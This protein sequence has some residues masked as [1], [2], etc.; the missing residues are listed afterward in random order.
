MLTDDDLASA[1]LALYLPAERAVVLTPARAHSRMPARA[2]SSACVHC[3]TQVAPGELLCHSCCLSN[4]S[5]SP[6][7]T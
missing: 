3:G 7:M 6:T 1:R 4:C 5:R 2:L